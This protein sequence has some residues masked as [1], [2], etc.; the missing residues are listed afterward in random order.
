LK[1]AH[2]QVGSVLPEGRKIKAASIR[3]V[4]SA[5]MLCSATE[6]GLGEDAAGIIELPDD[7]PL[8]AQLRDYLSLDDQILDI[9]L[10]PNR[11]D[12]FSVTGV[13][14][15]I[16]AEQGIGMPVPAVEPV[17]PA[18]DDRFAVRL[19]AGEGCG[20][21]AGRVIRNVATNVA[22]P[23][24]LAE[25]LRRAGL[26]AIHP[27]VDVTNYVMLELGQP[28]HG[29]DLGKLDG[30]II[31]RHAKA[32]EKLALLD[33][34]EIELDEDLVVISD[35]SGPIGL[36]GIMGGLSTAVDDSTLDVFFE[37]A[38]F[39]PAA[40]SGRARRFG[41]HT[42]ASM[43][44]ER[45][46][47]PTQQTRAIERA[48]ALLM[49]IAGG[50]PGPVVEVVAAAGLPNVEPITLRGERLGAVLGQAL[51]PQT[52]E[53]SLELLGMVVTAKGG[54][55]WQVTPPS[56]RFDLEIEEDLIEEVAR[57]V[58]YDNIP[59]VPEFGVSKLGTASE[60]QVEEE[61]LADTL[62]AHGYSEI[63]SYSFI[64]AALG[65]LVNPGVPPERLANPISSD[66]SVMRRSLWPGL[67]SAAAQNLSRQQD[68]LR[69]FEIGPQFEAGAE[70]TTETA[71]VAGLACGA[72]WPEHWDLTSDDVDFFDVKS[73][74]EALVEL[75]GRRSALRF[76]AAEHP[77]LRPGRTARIEL[78]GAD[79]GWLG[80]L[81]PVAQ[82]VLDLKK[83][84]ILFALR[85]DCMTTALLPAYHAYSRFPSLRRDLAI[86][87]ANDV[88][89]DNVIACVRD[90]AGVNL[91]NVN[92]FD[93][94]RGPGIDSSRK[95]IG[96]GL[97]LQDSYRTLTDEDADRT[98][99]AVV[100]H[101]EREL[102][103]TI[104]N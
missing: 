7:A 43:R 20:R 65:E 86:V 90:A 45:G 100:E 84:P 74:V 42:D 88:E 72:R 63:I 59:A 64:D 81:H 39:S 33:A 78:G 95:S 73:D 71:V 54:N 49:E 29:Y 23:I 76:R 87:V 36:A 67:L 102:G 35:R 69:L 22:S 68:R 3:G 91:Q 24:W 13:A 37:A 52:V 77:V 60:D 1:A 16:A 89:A 47:D 27:V 98:V 34:R 56:F 9:D 25:R 104:R 58:G 15:E 46:V 11:G 17:A 50:E 19:D 66:L 55:A 101:L 38:Y 79:A 103:A 82:R 44:F 83:T 26:R 75:G 31:V 48:T 85:L 12:C 61:A 32:G 96:L 62:V 93:L 80:E 70:G 92:V 97:I 10:T 94:Y 57:L 51:S 30:E 18:N 40:V 2:A 28:L 99:A 8:G 41:L 21:F 53:T 4:D 6:L 5:G 14:R